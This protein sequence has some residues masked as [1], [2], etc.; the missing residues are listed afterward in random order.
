MDY[1]SSQSTGNGQLTITV[2]FKIGTN[3][4]TAL[5]LTH[6]RVQDTLSR[7]PQEVQ[8]QGVQVKKTIPA[9]LLGVHPYSPDGSRSAAYISNYFILHVRDEIARLPGVADF[10][11]LGERQYAMRIWIDPDKAAASNISASDILNVLRAQNAQ[12]SAGTLNQPPVFNDTGAAYQINVRALGRLTTPEQF[13]DIIVKS[14]SQGRVTRIRDIGRV[15]LGS[16]DYGSIAY[17]DRHAS[18]PSGSSPRQA[19]MWS[20]WS[21]KCGTRWGSSRRVSRRVLITSTS[22]TRPPSSASPSMK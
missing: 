3:I 11:V 13:G 5:M 12:V 10:W 8:L 16:V 1:I 21:T 14:D 15:E 19:R 9:L 7:L 20:G 18:A 2:I 17:A 4:N 22:T 6:N